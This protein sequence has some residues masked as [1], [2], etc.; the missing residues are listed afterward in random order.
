MNRLVALALCFSIVACG[1][2]PEVASKRFLT[3]CAAA[4]FTPKQCAFMLA[5]KGEQDEANSA[6]AAASSAA[7]G[8]AAT[9]MGLAVGSQR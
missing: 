6:N 1:E 3:N 5:M 9:S 7:M 8:M 2:S 4:D